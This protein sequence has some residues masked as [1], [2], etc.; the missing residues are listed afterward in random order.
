[1]IRLYIAGGVLAALLALGG[2]VWLQSVQLK[3]ARA[4]LASA[5]ARAEAAEFAAAQSAKVET[6]TRTV[7]IQAE[8]AKANVLKTDPQCAA[9][10]S[11]L[12]AWRDGLRSLHEEAERADY[13][14]RRP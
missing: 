5:K 2:Y 4:D 6:I 11:T 8:K 10:G 12:D 1:M 14:A 7:Y 13:T 3:Q 9:A